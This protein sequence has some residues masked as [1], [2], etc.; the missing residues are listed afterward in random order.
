MHRTTLKDQHTVKNETEPT[1]QG[2]SVTTAASTVTGGKTE[3][4]STTVVK[5]QICQH[6]IKAFQ[7]TQWPPKA[8]ISSDRQKEH[9]CCIKSTNNFLSAILYKVG[10]N[11]YFSDD[12]TP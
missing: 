11:I 4:Y 1:Q 2:Y 5:K 12:S 3:S 9:L 6:L 8:K 10:E 7:P